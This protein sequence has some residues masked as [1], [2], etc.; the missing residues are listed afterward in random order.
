[1]CIQ[2][3]NWITY[4]FSLRI[5]MVLHLRETHSK[6]FWAK[7]IEGSV[8]FLRKVFVSPCILVLCLNKLSVP[9]ETLCKTWWFLRTWKFE[10]LHLKK[11]EHSAQVIQV[12]KVVYKSHSIYIVMR[13]D[14]ECLVIVSFWSQ[15]I[16]WVGGK[17]VIFI[18]VGR[19]QWGVIFILVP[20]GS[21][22]IIR[23]RQIGKFSL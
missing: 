17:G 2:W 8:I 22:R 4:Y 16:R 15:R 18:L 19:D 21:K 6:M 7:L 13:S 20:E 3:T 23:K 12:I 5:E 10:K 9:I 14:G 11:V 1:M